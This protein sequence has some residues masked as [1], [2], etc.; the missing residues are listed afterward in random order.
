MEDFFKQISLLTGH[1]P[2]VDRPDYIPE[3]AATIFGGG[4]LS[5]N[6]LNEILLALGYDLISEDFF[7]CF[8]CK[9]KDKKLMRII[10]LDDFIKAVNDFRI[11]A[12]LKYGNF[13]FAYKN[14][15]NMSLDDIL[16]AKKDYDPIDEVT[17]KD[18]P[19]PIIKLEEIN[20]KDTYLL[21][22]IAGKS[23]KELKIKKH[24]TAED[25]DKI[26]QREKIIKIGKNNYKKYLTYDYIDVYIATSMRRKEDFYSV[27]DFIKKLSN[28]KEVEELN[29]RY[30]DPTQADPQDK[31]AKGL[32][33]G[34][35]VKRAKC[36][37][38]CVQES[39][40]FGKDSELAA[41]LAQGK[42]VI[43]YIPEIKDLEKYKIE[44]TKL[45][46][47]LARGKNKDYI[48]NMLIE[49]HPQCSIEEPQL[50]NGKLSFEQMVKELAI[51]DQRLY[52]KRAETLHENH[53]LS[54]QIN[55]HTGVANGLL[56]VRNSNEC[57]KVLR[58]IILRSLEFK[59]IFH[60]SEDAEYKS[61]IL[62]EKITGSSYR[63]VTCDPELTNSFW[64]FYLR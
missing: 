37:I 28:Q 17:Y 33:E 25:K 20:K 47:E 35:M 64:N 5:Y 21:G 18:R 9:S 49:R 26:E 34:L 11:F 1:E 45:V 3:S 29:L 38:Y 40:T 46:K 55:L 27:Y 32:I 22:H 36:T 51:R 54:I 56:I 50:V 8:L 23:V 61:Y 43:A 52:D 7:N 16:K 53:P 4:G 62:E 44:I 15:S 48:K 42:P 63:V 57:A 24:K 59:I 13:K 30:F 60:G 41:T 2:E 39:D 6:Q 31:T 19:R 14:V 12:M 10:N 58:G